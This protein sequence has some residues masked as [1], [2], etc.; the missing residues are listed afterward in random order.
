[1]LEYLILLRWQKKLE[2]NDIY[3]LLNPDDSDFEDEDIRAYDPVYA[4]E[5]QT[6]SG[7]QHISVVSQ[8]PTRLTPGFLTGVMGDAGTCRINRSVME[9]APVFSWI[10]VIPGDLQ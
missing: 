6:V 5:N 4:G 2:M 1:M 10:G 8:K 3:K 7:Q 9:R